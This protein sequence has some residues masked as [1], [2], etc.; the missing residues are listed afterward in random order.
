MPNHVVL[1]VAFKLC[2]VFYGPLLKKSIAIISKNGLAMEAKKLKA[3][4]IV[5]TLHFHK[6]NCLF[7]PPEIPR[8][9]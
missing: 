2:I 8:V 6:K 3:L 5:N 1:W 7:N 4:Q 9:V